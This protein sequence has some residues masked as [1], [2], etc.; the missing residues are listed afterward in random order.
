ML[1][2]YRTLFY[3]WVVIIALAV[4][5]CFNMAFATLN[6]GLFIRPMG[7]QLGITRTS[8]GWAMSARMGVGALTSPMIGRIIDRY[9]SRYIILFATMITGSAVACLGLITQGWQLITLF[10]FM[11]IIAMVGPANLAIS[12]PV[13]KWFIK[14]KGIALAIVGATSALGGVI[15][16]PLSQTFIHLYGWR[17]SWFMLALIGSSVIIPVSFIFVRRQPEDFGLYPDGESPSGEII[18]SIDDESLKSNEPF[19]TVREVIVTVKFWLL[20]I[21]FG[22]VMLSLSTIGIHRIPNFID[23]GLDPTTV[24]FATSLDPLAFG[25]STFL[26]GF[27]V[28][29]IPI[30]FI[31]GIGMIGLSA[32]IYLS[33]VGN[34]SLLMCLSF[35]IFGLAMG[36]IMMMN[37]YIWPDYYGRKFLGS[38]R[39]I[40]TPITLLG[41]G[42]GAPLAGYIKDVTGSYDSI[43]LFMIVVLI[44]DAFVIVFVKPPHKNDIFSL[45]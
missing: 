13:A 5:S 9:G 34:T 14:K 44:I 27:L 32:A 43:W 16:V 7:D 33:I 12:V 15:F 35:I 26:F 2:I 29:K 6:F 20:A 21:L 4:I 28:Q 24:A 3:G 42:A 19:W 11:G 45:F 17:T 31:G 36:A 39:G 18:D 8:F 40:V 38:I 25:I 22:S 10:G 41:S 23:Q 37:N 1:N 30:R